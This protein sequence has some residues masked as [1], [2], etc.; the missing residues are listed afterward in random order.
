MSLGTMSSV[1]DRLNKPEYWFR[2]H[3]IFRKIF[4]VLGAYSGTLQAQVRL[5]WK[6]QIT[7]NPHETI[8]KSLLTC[9][10]YELAVTEIL[11]RLTD[12]GDYCVDIGAHIG[13]MTSVFAVRAGGTGKVF[14]FEP[15]P[16]IFRTL[17]ANVRGWSRGISSSRYADVSVIQAALGSNG[18][19]MYLVEPEGFMDNEGTA[20]LLKIAGRSSLQRTKH[21]VRVQNLDTYF[22]ESPQLGI[23]KIDVEGA[24]L[25]VLNGALRL[26]NNRKIR[27]IVL[28]D[29]QPYPSEC[30]DLLRDHS[31]TIFRVAKSIMGPVIWDPADRNAVYRSLPWEPVNYIATFDPNRLALRL[32]PRGW[33]CLR[34]KP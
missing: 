13:Y 16:R 25:A 31:Y 15:H 21:R 18:S 17:K 27:D 14:S 26:L 34:A 4:F 33:F 23:V 19:E 22:R 20:A 29:F 3:Q 24:E 32:R 7:L 8:G 11:W 28:E 1:S 10:V 6:A 12:P 9:G 30:I 5:P 2:P